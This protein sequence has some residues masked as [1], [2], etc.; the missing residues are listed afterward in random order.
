M[1]LPS[2]PP[3]RSLMLCAVLVAGVLPGASSA[4][5]SVNRYGNPARVKPAPTTPAIT[6]RDLQ[7]RL[8]QFADDSMQ[9]R[10]VGRV[11]NR[12]ATDFL[13][14][15]AK[16]I[17]LLPAGTNGGYFQNLPYH[18]RKF[19]DQSLVVVDG[20]PL[21]WNTDVVAVPGQRAPRPVVNAEVIFGGTQGDT[22]TQISGAEAV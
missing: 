21:G 4:Q 10:Q 3:F 12:K 16:R 19:T 2:A 22:T 20:N 7:I 11:G 6:V 15:E 17:G 13:A 5:T 14:S 8:Y 1:M 9:G 18:L